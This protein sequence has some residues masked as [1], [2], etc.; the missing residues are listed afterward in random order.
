[1]SLHNSYSVLKKTTSEKLFTYLLS[2][3]GFLLEIT[4]LTT[5]Y[6][7]HI[8]YDNGVCILAASG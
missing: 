2:L 8:I 5:I 4:Q 3:I 1:M 7:I 6:F